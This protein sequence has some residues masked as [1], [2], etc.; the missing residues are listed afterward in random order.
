VRKKGAWIWPL[1]GLCLLLVL[2]AAVEGETK[3]EDDGHL[4]ARILESWRSLRDEMYQLVLF[5]LTSIRKNSVNVM[6]IVGP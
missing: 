5:F 3:S 4:M 2:E 1:F 6:L